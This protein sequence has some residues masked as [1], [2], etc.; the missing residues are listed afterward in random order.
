VGLDAFITKFAGDGLLLGDGLLGQAVGS[1]ALGPTPSPSTPASAEADT[2]NGTGR[3]ENTGWNKWTPVNAAAIDAHLPA[4]IRVGAYRRSGVRHDH[5]VMAGRA[6]AGSSPWGV[7]AVVN[8]SF[9]WGGSR[10]WQRPASVRATEFMARRLP[11][12]SATCC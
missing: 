3:V 2:A 6:G 10:W 8:V 1:V 12:R 5:Q 4:R 11:S 7:Q 9:P